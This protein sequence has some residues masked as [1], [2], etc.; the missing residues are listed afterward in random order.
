MALVLQSYIMLRTRDRRFDPGTRHLFSA[1]SY[2]VQEEELCGRL[3]E[4]AREEA[5]VAGRAR[6]KK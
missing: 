2:D 5:R 4:R 6:D 1:C 3:E